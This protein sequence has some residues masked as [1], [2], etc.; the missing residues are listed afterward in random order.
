MWTEI[1]RIYNWY[2]CKNLMVSNGFVLLW[3]QGF[4][5]KSNNLPPNQKS[6]ENFYDLQLLMTYIC[7]SP[8]F[9]KR[10]SVRSETYQIQSQL[11]CYN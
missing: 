6:G 2:G 8:D 10:K 1:G 5:S 9:T 7:S 11:K 4:E 3:S